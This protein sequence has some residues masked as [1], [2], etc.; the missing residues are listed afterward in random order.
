MLDPSMNCG[1]VIQGLCPWCRVSLKVQQGLAV[2]PG[3]G[4]KWPAECAAPQKSGAVSKAE[5]K[6][7]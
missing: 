2:C 5:T 1:M 6:T 7:S 4:G 3:C